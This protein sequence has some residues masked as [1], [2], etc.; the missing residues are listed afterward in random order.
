MSTDPASCSSI[1][2]HNFGRW[3]GFLGFFSADTEL[4][5][6]RSCGLFSD[7]RTA[8]YA[9]ISIGLRLSLRSA[10]PTGFEP[11]LQVGSDRAIDHD[12]NCEYRYQY[13]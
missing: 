3:F 10:V 8:N 9:V 13:E 1:Q 5:V 2:A 12:G 7:F 4:R 11:R 6:P